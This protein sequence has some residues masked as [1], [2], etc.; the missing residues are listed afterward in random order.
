MNTNK[1]ILTLSDLE[2]FYS[3]YKRS[4]CFSSKK[5]GYQLAVQ[6][7]ATFE[8][9]EYKD[10]TMLFCN[11]K[12]FHIGLNRNHSCVTEDAAKKAMKTIAYKPIL[13]NFCE[14]DGERDFT[15]HDMIIKDSSI[16][17]IERQIGC[18]T[19]DEPYIERDEDLG[20]DFVYAKCAIPREYTDA[21]DI[22]ERKNGTKVSVELLINE[23]QYNAKEKYL[24]LTDVVVQ[25]ATCLGRNPETGAFVEEGMLGARLDIADFS[26]SNNS[27]F[28]NQTEETNQKLIETLEKLN[29]TLTKFNIED[30]KS[31]EIY[32]KEEQKSMN[33][34]IKVEEE[35]TEVETVEE[36][37]ETVE[38]FT[39]ENVEEVV[40]ETADETVEEVTETEE[41]TEEV[42]ETETDETVEEGTPE[43]G[44]ETAETVEV[45]E[46]AEVAEVEETTD[47]VK[48]ELI[49]K[50]F[51]VDGRKFSISFE[52]SHSDIAYGLYTLLE[53]Y[54]DLDNEWYDI[55]AVYDD[56]FVFQGW[57]TGKIY[58]QKY[59]KDGDTV[60]LD[61]ERF[62][63]FEELLTATEKSELE[64][65]RSN[66]SAIQTELS[67][68]KAAEEK[69]D[70]M[71]VFEDEN[72][73]QFL[74]TP[75]FKEL[76]ESVDQY[77]KEELE[78]KANIAFSKLVKKNKTFAL[79][80]TTEEK[81]KAAVFAFGRIET[82]SS[83][84]DGLLGKDKK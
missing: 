21:V 46:T 8:A 29:E 22:I 65:I 5:T 39:E 73:A 42:A 19:A 79:E 17:Y 6:I 34:E 76:M 27:L 57:F 69:A 53:S 14:I 61:G 25:G 41:F 36:T 52:L 74:E 49:E 67:T 66:Y 44:E 12:L 51:E 28:A 81:P 24:E 1:K 11:V 48:F 63:L 56:R 59:T 16:E 82:K 83:F 72:Y 40:E 71:T 35:V 50:S 10:D 31:N 64:L 26:Q 30:S 9:E 23:M 47:E 78:D 60:A 45:V 70:K 20:V 75:E 54:C 3:K 2:Q 58:G 13:A 43:V 38:E 55:R 80:T 62:E 33:E 77:S 7:P 4:T 84:L 68:Y 37:A 15:A 18:F 32:G